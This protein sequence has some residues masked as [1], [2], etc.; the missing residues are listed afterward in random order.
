MHKSVKFHK[1]FSFRQNIAI[2]PTKRLE[3]KTNKKGANSF[4]KQFAYE[5]WQIGELEIY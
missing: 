4:T 2:K 1:T 3:Y 5:N